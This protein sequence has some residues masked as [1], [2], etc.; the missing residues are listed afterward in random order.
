MA[1]S[2]PIDRWRRAPRRRRCGPRLRASPDTGR[3]GSR[4]RRR[5]PARHPSAGGPAP[6]VQAKVARFSTIVRTTSS[7][8]RR[9]RPSS[10]VRLRQRRRL[11]G[12]DAALDPER[13]A[14]DHEGERARPRR[15]AGRDRRRIAP[16][17]RRRRRGARAS[18]PAGR[19]RRCA[20]RRWRSARSAARR[21]SPP[22]PAA[23]GPTSRAASTALAATT[24]RSALTPSMRQPAAVALD[25]L[26]AMGE[27][28]RR[29]VA[30]EPGQRGRGKDV[31]EADARQQQVGAA[32][33]SGQGVAQHAQEDGA[34]RLA[35][36]RV[37]RGDAE[38]LDEVASHG[39]RQR[40][41]R[42]RRRSR[43]A[44]RESPRGASATRPE[45]ARSARAT[46]S[47]A[48]RATAQANAAQRRAAAACAG[49]G[50]RH[51]RASAA[52][53]RRRRSRSTPTSSSRRSVSR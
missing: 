50:L 28:D 3:R 25:P 19:S 1:N 51:R 53:A 26:D 7:G 44:S 52:A 10:R 18:A 11:G 21:P 37:E 24:T 8:A 16:A 5:V 23:C 20:R 41:R 36:R 35:R 6:G 32:G 30:L 48:G 31:A 2:R 22:T 39:G 46:T 13:R 27:P 38:R 4:R 29:A 12:R 33:A 47:R 17:G 45:A 15:R 9:K 40:R 34:A 42:G 43:R 49:R 14:A